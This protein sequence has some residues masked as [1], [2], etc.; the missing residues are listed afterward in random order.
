MSSYLFQWLLKPPRC[1]LQLMAEECSLRHGPFWRNSSFVFPRELC[2]HVH[3]P[4]ALSVSTAQCFTGIT[5][6][7]ASVGLCRGLIPATLPGMRLTPLMQGKLKGFRACLKPLESSPYSHPVLRMLLV[8]CAMP[9]QYFV[10]PQH[11]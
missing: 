9:N 1:L 3:I 10:V 4:K 2:F 8:P 6:V 7:C 5:I 11:H